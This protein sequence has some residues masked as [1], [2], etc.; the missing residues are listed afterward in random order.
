MIRINLLPFRAARKKENVRRQVSIFLL[1][2]ILVGA[3]VI[4]YNVYLSGKIKDLNASIKE[5]KVQLAKY[6][7]INAEIKEIKKNLELLNK[8][9]QVIETLE[10]NRREPVNLLA[11]LTDL[12]M[13]ERMWFTRLSSKGTKVN[14]E[15]IAL[16]NQTV[17]DFMTRLERSAIYADVNLGT[18]KQKELK[19]ME[20][21]LKSFDVNVQKVAPKK[22]T[23][24]KD[25]A[26]AKPTPKRS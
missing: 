15:G 4:Y 18:V 8:K 3:A 20:L 5:T 21:T 10:T 2:L 22:K 24:Q 26:K 17:S 25:A 7:K 16:D 12:I 9:I 6:N 19:T 13:A 14:I 1:S 23:P 11:S